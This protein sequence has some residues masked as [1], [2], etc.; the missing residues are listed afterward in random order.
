MAR[1]YPE[2]IQ[3]V[4]M[5][6]QPIPWHAIPE[7]QVFTKLQTNLSGLSPE[8]VEERLLEFGR[9][10][11]P[12]RK[13][14]TL[15]DIVLHQ[16]KSPLIYILMIAGI[17]ALLAGDIKDAVFILVVI[18]LNAAIGA[19]QEWRAE[20]SAHALQ[21]L[22][23]VQARVRREGQR[24]SIPSEELALGDVVLLESG[25][26][27]PADLRLIEANNL[28]ID[29]AFLTGESL[30]ST[31]NVSLVERDIPVSDRH[32]M[33]YAG[34]TVASGRGIGVV[35]ATGKYTE[36]G[37]IAF[38]VAEEE[39]AKPPLVLRMEKFAQQISVIVLG[40]A[41]LLGVIAFIRG[42]DLNNALFLVIAMA[43]SAIPEGLP[44]A[45]TVALSLSTRRM[46]NRNVIVRKLAAVE[47]LGSCTVIAS[48]KTGTLTVNQQTVR[49]VAFPGGASVMVSGQGYNDEGDIT[50]ENGKNHNSDIDAWLQTI[51]RDAILC[52]EA[53]LEKANGEW[54]H[55][56]DAMDIALLALGYK[57]GLNP[58]QVRQD[59][60]KLGEIPFESEKRYAATW[61]ELNGTSL[62][63]AK[64]AVETVLPFCTQ[65]QTQKGLSSLDSDQ[66]QQHAL[67]LAK[68]GYRVLALA[69]GEVE[70]SPSPGEFSEGDLQGLTLQA[71]VGFI[72]PL[73][74]EAR[75]AVEKALQAGI[76]VV[77]I[78]GDHP[79]TALAIARE[80]GIADS[81]AQVVTGQE[82]AEI[83]DVHVPEFYERVKH[84]NVFA[85]VSPD[86]KLKIVETLM[87]LGNFV[88][89]TGD[90]VN[91]APALR[92]ANIGVAMGS[93]TDVAKDTASLIVTDDNFASIVAGIEEG[94]HAYANVRKVTLLL[95]STGLA[96]LILIGLSIIVGFPAPL[97]AVQILWLNLVTNGIQDVALAFEAGEKGVMRLPPRKPT[98]GIFNAKMIEQ[99]LVSGITMAVVSFIAWAWMMMNGWQEDQARSS[100]LTL[101][102]LMQFYHVLNC[103]S[104]YTSAFK[105]PLRNNPALVVGMLLAFVIH[106][107][108]TE[109]AFLQ[110]LLRTQ[111]LHWQYWLI[112]ALVGSVILIA[113]EVYKWVIK[114]RE[115]SS[116]NA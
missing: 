19:A 36:V 89:V 77:M 15:L 7:E 113:L 65:M 73:R 107:L 58:Q 26:K 34:S 87:G 75:Q 74:P 82:L 69:S 54:R 99:V 45:M 72:D 31:K 11:L 39:G 92:K 46:A 98:E 22:I 86:Q 116:R 88:A 95:I 108:A 12:E 17:I 14:P 55:N 10:I 83:G 76:K 109:T 103:R 18:V 71:L 97:L 79:A 3:L 47:S 38:T 41:A 1:E 96:E 32:N 24:L 27:V 105:V 84:S 21:Q 9:N 49:L 29:E 67:E 102:V 66:I 50:F 60:R 81:E 43:V 40:F 80:L 100:L 37:K 63:I 13:P 111:S 30:A 68:G 101:L 70:K 20:Q 52:N 33:A 25:D 44:V 115:E 78:T 28:T 16:F 91:D 93:G 104:E 110:S 8:Q 48:D 64:G 35:V 61:H 23:K 4:E 114:R 106:I 6:G 59:H 42:M 90:G 62:M 5:P 2:K 56:G 57:L 51:G 94:R 53:E 112:Y 85:R